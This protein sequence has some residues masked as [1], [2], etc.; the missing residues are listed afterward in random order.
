MKSASQS[1]SS[2]QSAGGLPRYPLHLNKVV[3]FLEAVRKELLKMK[4]GQTLI[5]AL[6]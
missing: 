4:S 3:D 5:T 1:V 6:F 2:L